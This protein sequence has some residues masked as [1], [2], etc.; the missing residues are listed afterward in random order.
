MEESLDDFKAIFYNEALQ[1]CPKSTE[2]PFFSSFTKLDNLQTMTVDQIG[3]ANRSLD[4]K[5][6]LTEFCLHCLKKGWDLLECIF[7]AS[8]HANCF[9]KL[10]LRFPKH[11]VIVQRN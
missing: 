7:D 8:I 11:V 10:T 4:S 9:E 2:D 5:V 3:T 6:V 1:P